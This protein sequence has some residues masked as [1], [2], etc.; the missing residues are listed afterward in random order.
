M[1]KLKRG[2]IRPLLL[3]NSALILILSL[4]LGAAQLFITSPAAAQRPA[5]LP[6]DRRHPP[7]QTRRKNPSF[8]RD[9]RYKFSGAHQ[10][11]IN[12]ERPAL[13]LLKRMFRPSAPYAGIQHTQE[14]S[15]YSEQIVKED[16]NGKKLIQFISPSNLAGEIIISSPTVFYHYFPEKNQLYTA[17]WPQS[18]SELKMHTLMQMALHGTLRVEITGEEKIDNIDCAIVSISAISRNHPDGILQRKLWIDKQTGALLRTERW[19]ERGMI[20]VSYMTQIKIGPGAGVSPRD[21]SRSAFPLN[22]QIDPLF[23]QT[24]PYQ[25]IEAAQQ[26][27]PFQILVPLTLPNSFKPDGIWV[28]TQPGNI[29]VLLRYTHGVNHFSLF[30]RRAYPK[31]LHVRLAPPPHPHGSFV[32]WVER[33]PDGSAVSI[34]YIGHIGPKALKLMADSIR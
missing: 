9:S 17:I 6:K 18:E 12:Q 13:A 31:G 21:F 11:G 30:E 2:L 10:L 34:L 20:S 29:S 23:P 26:Q 19:G 28:F 27:T 33:T 32:H 15:R 25:S 24:P 22:S 7:V 8:H 5:R 3:L 14:G 16:T 4:F 1:P